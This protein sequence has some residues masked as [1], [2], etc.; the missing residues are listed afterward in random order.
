MIF[1]MNNQQIHNVAAGK[2]GTDAVN[3]DQLNEVQTLDRKSVV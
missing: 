1:L 3:V 2:K